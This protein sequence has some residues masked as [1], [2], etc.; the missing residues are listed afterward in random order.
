MRRLAQALAACAM[1]QAGAAAALPAFGHVVI[2][3]EENREFTQVI[4]NPNV[5]YLNS[6]A[7]SFGLA[8]NFFADVHP[9]IGNYFMMTAGSTVTSNDQF[10]GTVPDD[11][12]V[13]R[14][15]AGGQSWK[16]YAEAIPSAGDLGAGIPPY[17]RWHNPLSFF[18][19]V[20]NDPAQAANLVPFSQF[21]ADLAA[22][23][24]PRYAFV[25]PDLDHDAHNGTLAEADA[26]LEA[27]IAPL[28]ADP[29]FQQD[30]L[31][32]ICFDEGT[33]DTNGGGRIAWLAA[34][35]YS[36]SAFQSVVFYRHASTLR[37]SAAG[38]GLA[39][40]PGA[41]AAAPDMGEFF[42]AARDTAAPGAPSALRLRGAAPLSLTISWTPATDDL[43][44]SRYLVDVSTDA[45]FGS[46]VGGRDRTLLNLA[47]RTVF[48]AGGLTPGAVYHFRARAEDAAGNRSAYSPVFTASTPPAPDSARD[49]FAF[50]NPFRPAR[51]PAFLTFAKTPAGATVRIYT[52]TGDLVRE[53]T[54]D[55]GGRATWDGAN[56]SGR[57][58]A[59]GI[60]FA[61]VRGGGDQKTV[62]FAIER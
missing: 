55:R 57:P 29:A 5:P 33:T 21:P 43:Y 42:N 56:G 3:V 30:G 12:I 54:A 52:M 51:G 34:S 16:A 45:A 9:S 47:G 50:P 1:L 31:L 25:V 49:A 24:L 53:L 23:A 7:A 8:T 26:W 44:V 2:V 37:L 6:L 60:Y 18:T 58:A 10:S 11:N 13:R 22:N 59:S 20:V 62:R 41:A 28:L 17:A 35:P 36:K 15:I 38:L 27:H 14:L 19:D 61:V 39:A 32:I 40:F 48:T 4:G 46:F